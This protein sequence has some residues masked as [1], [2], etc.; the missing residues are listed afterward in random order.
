VGGVCLL[1]G[2][3]PSG[4][5]SSNSVPCCAVI[6]A[7]RRE[8]LTAGRVRRSVASTSDGCTDGR[9]DELSDERP[10]TERHI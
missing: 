10:S 1:P 9:T 7:L 8:D 6:S 4:A 3:G 5:A 2:A